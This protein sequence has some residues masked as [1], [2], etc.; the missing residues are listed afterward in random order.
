M[1]GTRGWGAREWG[2]C[3]AEVDPAAGEPDSR[4]EEE[5]LRSLPSAGKG[6]CPRPERDLRVV[7]KSC[8]RPEGQSGKAVEKWNRLAPADTGRCLRQWQIYLAEEQRQHHFSLQ[9]QVQTVLV[10]M[11]GLFILLMTVGR[12]LD[13]LGVFVSLLGELWCV[14]GVR[15][16]IDLCQ[17]QVGTSM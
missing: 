8:G 2:V 11:G 6:L 3:Q 7:N 1:T 4:A 5:N 9:G 16:L 13:L 10:R 15:I 14:A 12:W 17:I